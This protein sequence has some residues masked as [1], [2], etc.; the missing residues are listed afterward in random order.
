MLSIKG[1][2]YQAAIFGVTVTWLVPY[3][4]NINVPS[5]VDVR[6]MGTF[7]EFYETVLHFINFKLFFSIGWKYPPAIDA[8][9]DVVTRGLTAYVNQPCTL[10][11][12][13]VHPPPSLRLT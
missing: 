2:Y 7:L 4:F 8:E 3:A 13:L 1:V 6:V 9:V 5:E 10:D 12:D 11:K